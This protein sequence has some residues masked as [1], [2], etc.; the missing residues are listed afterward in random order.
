[1]GQPHPGG[2]EIERLAEGVEQIEELPY[3][4]KGM[5]FS[6]SGL[7]TETRRR[8]SSTDHELLANSFQE[9]AYA[10]C[11]EALERAMSQS[12]S[13]EA[14][15]TGGVAMNSRLRQM[16]QEMCDQ[17][18][19]EFHVPPDEF[20]MD[21]GAM[22]AEQGRLELEA[23]RTTPIESSGKRPDWRPDEVEVEW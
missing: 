17:R 22:I 8:L 3:P 1:M 14:M 11:V 5:D 20:C 13:G 23:G 16:A 4:V 15:L 19:A 2:P 7:V 6:F 18:G 10:A 21:N 9:H 12:G